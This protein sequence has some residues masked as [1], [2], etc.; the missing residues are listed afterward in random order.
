MQSH[1]PVDFQKAVIE[2]SL[3]IPVL[4]DFWAPWCAPCSS[5]APVLESLAERH[6]GE[7]ILV[8]VNT[9]E[10]PEIAS[11]YGVRGIPNVKLFSN[12]DVIDEFTGALAEYQI[13]Q[14]LKKVLPGPWAA[15]VERAAVEMSAGNDAEAIALL[16]GVLGKEHDN[17]RA[18]AML[19]KLTLFS[20]PEEALK[21][22]ELLEG[23]PEHADLS[24]A[25]RTLAPLL[26]RSDSD[27]PDG[28]AR[29][30]YR[31]A[32]ETLSLGDMDGALASFIGVLR[33]NRYYDNDGSR[34][35]CIAIFRI[36]GE[37]H[38]TTQKHRRS[39]DRAF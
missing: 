35:A 18:A 29:E 21:L 6:A 31:S 39:F 7:W 37:E 32:V 20:R 19:T 4:V 10:Y 38:Q 2:Q 33:E 11:K 3:N 12:G 9:E 26:M 24:E 14:W 17:R 27:L 5:L 22:V 34:K 23:E 28:D 1:T 36:L 13:E 16:E 8:K 25:V 30:A 15:D